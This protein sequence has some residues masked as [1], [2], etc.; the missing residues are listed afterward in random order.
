MPTKTLSADMSVYSDIEL[1]VFVKHLSD[2]LENI[3]SLS[4]DEEYSNFDVDLTRSPIFFGFTEVARKG[5]ERILN[6][7]YT[8]QELRNTL[9][10]EMMKKLDAYSTAQLTSIYY[11]VITDIEQH[12]DLLSMLSEEDGTLFKKD[13]ELYISK[14]ESYLKLITDVIK[15]RNET[16]ASDGTGDNSGD[17]TG[18]NSGSGDNTGDNTN[19]GG[20]T[21]DTGEDNTGSNQEG[22]NTDPGE[23][24]D[25]D[26]SE[27]TGSEGT[28][29]NTGTE[30]GTGDG[31][32]SGSEDPGDAVGSSGNG[33]GVSN[34]FATGF[35]MSYSN[36]DN[37]G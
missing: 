15:K 26:P 17:N 35:G 11:T 37:E 32:G 33:L 18:D 13:T 36:P 30:D 29:E 20:D 16:P 14:Q 19:P 7:I 22:G 34:P 28:G 5:I 25:P 2:A 27:N 31:D 4:D 9:K 1:E 8:E 12:K 21:P 23:N 10:E 24:T 3:E 6:T